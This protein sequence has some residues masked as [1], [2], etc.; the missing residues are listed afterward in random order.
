MAILFLFF[1]SFL[2]SSFLHIFS[3]SCIFTFSSPLKNDNPI[4]VSF[5]R[6]FSYTSGTQVNF[7]VKNSWSEARTKSNE[8]LIR[9][10]LGNRTRYQ[11]LNDYPGMQQVSWSNSDVHGSQQAAEAPLHHWL[12]KVIRSIRRSGNKNRLFFLFSIF[13][14]SFLRFFILY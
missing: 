14:F 2:F 9:T 6:S 4:S 3:S 12:E 5:H 10:L 8:T 13:S 1:L 11:W 7:L